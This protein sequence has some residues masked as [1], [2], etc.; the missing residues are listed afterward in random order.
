M[1]RLAAKRN[2]GGGGVSL[3]GFR[4]AGSPRATSKNGAPLTTS[5]YTSPRDGWGIRHEDVT[6]PTYP[7][8]AKEDYSPWKLDWNSD[9]RTLRTSAPFR[10]RARMYKFYIIIHPSR[11]AATQ[12]TFNPIDMQRAPI[13]NRVFATLPE[14]THQLITCGYAVLSRE[15]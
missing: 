10:P 8:T 1:G 12:H 11:G 3:H 2:G 4:S 6:F 9:S 5:L 14:S 15:I 7:M 13:F